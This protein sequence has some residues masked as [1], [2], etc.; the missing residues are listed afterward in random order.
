MLPEIENPFIRIFKKKK[1]FF[2]PQPFEDNNQGT[3]KRNRGNC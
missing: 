1:K 3:T 2:N